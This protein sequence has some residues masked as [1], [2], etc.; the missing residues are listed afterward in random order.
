LCGYDAAGGFAVMI[1]F[2]ISGFLVTK[3]ASERTTADYL[4]ARALRIL[5]ALACVVLF[6]SL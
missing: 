4:A 5:P 6:T 1:F 2:V 3:S